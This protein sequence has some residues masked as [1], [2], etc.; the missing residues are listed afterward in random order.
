MEAQP[1]SHPPLNHFLNPDQ[2]RDLIARARAED[3]GP[4]GLDLTSG[5]FI[6]AN[7]T[8]RAVIRCRQTGRLAGGAM[9]RAIATAYDAD[10]SAQPTIQDG[11]TVEAG[12]I[13]ARLAGPMRTVLALERVALNFMCHLSGIAT[14]TACYV[15]AVAK[16]GAS[17]TKIYDTRKTLPGLRALEKYAVTCGGG[18]SHRAGLFDAV[19]VKDNHI[20]NVRP[21]QLATVI[22]RASET[23]RR[24]SPP[25]AFFGVEVDTLDQLDRVLHIAPARVDIV[26]LDNMTPHQLKQAVDL[27]DRLAPNVELEASG[28]VNLDTI[29]DIALSGV[30]RVSIGK[31]T[32]SAPALDLA[33]DVE[34]NSA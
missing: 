25:P 24:T 27:R 1:G 22:Q 10:I 6:P 19:L 11:Q 2:L 29:C 21:D 9:L 18:H 31:I 34:P 16:A 7:Q 4:A 14:L 13:V 12:Q 3:L 28:G 5:C 33:L 17:N 20:A 23:T 30:D 32:H 15:R 8:C 26:L